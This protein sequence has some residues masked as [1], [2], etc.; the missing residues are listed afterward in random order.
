MKIEEN[1]LRAIC[2][3][4]DT[5]NEELPKNEKISKSI[6]TNLYGKNGNLDSLALVNL[7]VAVEEKIEDEF[8]TAITLADERAMSQS[9]SPFKSIGS[10]TNYILLLLNEHEQK[11][12]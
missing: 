9:K 12:T 2:S 8:G 10:L 11:K 5:I 7:I 3:A 4:V 6:E 1:V